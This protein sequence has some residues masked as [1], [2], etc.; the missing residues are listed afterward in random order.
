MN[1]SGTAPV[2][3]LFAGTPPD[4]A[5]AAPVLLKIDGYDLAPF[6]EGEIPDVV[7]DSFLQ[8]KSGVFGFPLPEKSDH[9]TFAET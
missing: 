2:W 9:L 3:A 8:R 6:R 1:N 5:D 7:D 4:V